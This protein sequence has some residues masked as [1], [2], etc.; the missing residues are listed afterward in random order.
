MSCE[1][2]IVQQYAQYLVFFQEPDPDQIRPLEVLRQTLAE[3]SRRWK[4][5]PDYLWTCDQLKS[6]RQDLTVK[7]LLRL[8]F[9]ND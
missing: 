7:H 2:V 6:L 3:L 4:E 9:T 1:I 8:V 5:N